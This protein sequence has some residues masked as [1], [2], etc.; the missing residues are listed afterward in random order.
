MSLLS[1]ALL[2]AGGALLAAVAV[3]VFIAWAVL[4]IGQVQD[5]LERDRDDW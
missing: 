5:D 2:V 3:I 4:S 1:I